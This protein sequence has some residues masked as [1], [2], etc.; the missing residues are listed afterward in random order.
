MQRKAYRQGAGRCETPDKKASP[1]E[2]WQQPVQ[3]FHED[4]IYEVHN[5]DDEE[6]PQKLSF[7]GRTPPLKDPAPCEDKANRD[8]GPE[9]QRQRHPV[10]DPEESQRTV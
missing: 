2:G 3:P 1:G 10:P 4:A 9:T 7:P 6:K 8:A 5:A